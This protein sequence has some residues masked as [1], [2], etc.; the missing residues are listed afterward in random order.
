[1]DTNLLVYAN[2]RSAKDKQTRAIDVIQHLMR[3][4]NGMLSIQVLQEYANVALTKL[5][6]DP[7]VVLRQL[8]LLES[9]KVITPTTEMLRRGIEICISYRVGFWDA[10][11]IAAAEAGESDV[12][13]SEDLNA[14][15][16]YAG[17]EVVNPFLDDFDLSLFL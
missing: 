14:G 7:A 6:Q 4:Q 5:S 15:Q 2:D 12:I 10:G 11:I 16:Y 3:A 9:L 17:I 1:M 8:R 13:L